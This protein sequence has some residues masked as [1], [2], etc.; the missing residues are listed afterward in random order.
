M[1]ENSK[2]PAAKQKAPAA[3]QKAP[4]V[5]NENETE[6]KRDWDHSVDVLVV[7]SGNGGLTAALCNQLMGAGEVLVIEKADKVGGTSATSGGGIWIPC[8]H[9]AQQAGADDS[10]GEAQQYLDQ[11]LAGEDIPPELVSSYLDNGPKMLKF[12]HEHTD[13]RYE[14]LEH[15]PDYYSTLPGAKP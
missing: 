14:S 7:G 6:T 11:T 9:Y 15:Y 2:A 12:M 13:V 10:V 5:G 8:S 4:A 3:K 1:T